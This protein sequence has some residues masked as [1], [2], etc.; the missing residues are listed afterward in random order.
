MAGLRRDGLQG[1]ASRAL[2]YVLT[3]LLAFGTT[4]A[5]LWAEG[6]ESLAA[7]ASQV[8][9]DASGAVAP[10]DAPASGDAPA[11]DA[12]PTDAAD[13]AAPDGLPQ[14]PEPAPAPVESHGDRAMATLDSEWYVV[15]QASDAD[16]DSYDRVEDAPRPGTTIFANVYDFDDWRVAADPSWSYQWMSAPTKSASASDYEPIEGQTSQ[17][18]EM[19]DDLAARLAGRYIAVRVSDGSETLWGPA[20]FGGGGLYA[21]HVLG[22]VQA[23][24]EHALSRVE[25]VRSGNRVDNDID[26]LLAPGDE[27]EARAFS[28]GGIGGGGAVVDPAEVEFAWTLLDSKDAGSGESLGS[29]ARVALRDDASMIGKYVKLEARSG[30]STV[31]CVKGP[32]AKKGALRLANISIEVP[33]GK[34]APST[35]DVLKAK[36][37][38]TAGKLPADGAVTYTWSIKRAGSPSFVELPG[39]TSKSIAVDDSWAGARL[40]VS[41]TA[42]GYN[43]VEAQT[44]VILA[45]G[46]AEA[47]VAALDADGF[48]PSPVYGGAENVAKL[49]DARLAALGHPDATVRVVSATT[50][51]G[52]ATVSASSDAANGDVAFYYEDPETTDRPAGKGE[53]RVEFAIELGG[54]VATWTRYVTI[55]WDMGRVQK[56][57]EQELATSLKASDL[58]KF[59]GGEADDAASTIAARKDLKLPRALSDW[60]TLE[61][62]SSDP[63]V[64]GLDG[65]VER[66]QDRDSAPVTLTATAAFKLADRSEPP[67]RAEKRFT[68]VAKAVVT[69]TTD[70][71]RIEAALDGFQFKAAGTS[72]PVDPASITGDVQLPTYRSLGLKGTGKVSY[73]LE[74]VEAGALELSGFRLNAKRPAPGMPDAHA[75]LVATVT[76]N[77]TTRSRRFELTVKALD[78]AEIDAEL[79]LMEKAKAGYADALLNGNASA[80]AVSS[81]LKGFQQVRLDESGELVWARDRAQVHGQ[82]I[83]PVSVDV[84]RPSEQ[85]D[86]FKSST[87]SI[88]ESETLRLMRTPEYNTRVTVTSCLSSEKYEGYYERYRDDESIDPAVLAKYK[89][90]SRQEVSATFTVIGTTGRPDPEAG[91]GV[92]VSARVVGV[93]EPAADGSVREETWIPLTEVA[94]EKGDGKTAWDVF[95]SALDD[96]GYTY[97]RKGGDP[98][99]ITAPDGRVLAMS[100]SAPWSYWSFYLNGEYAQSAPSTTVLADGDVIELRYAIAG[101]SILPENDIDIDPSA[102]RP[103]WG[104]DWPSFTEAN[105]PTTAPTPVEAVDEKWVLPLGGG[106]L[107]VVS[108]P[109]MA[110]DYIYAAAA[111]SL[112]KIDAAT[113]ADLAQGKLASKIDSTARMVYH[114]GIIVV[115]L[116]GGRLQALTADTLTTVWLTDALPDLDGAA[117]QSLG[118]LVVRDGYVFAGTTN[119]SNGGP[120]YMTCV[121]LKTGAVRWTRRADAG[122]YWAG[123]VSVGAYLVVG[124]DAGRVYSYDPATG[125]VRGTPCELGA[126]VRTTLVTDGNHVYAV[127]YDGVLHKLAV[128]G[129]GSVTEVSKISFGRTSSSSTPTIVGGKAVVCGQSPTEGSGP[130]MK[131]AAIFLIDLETMKVEREVTKTGSGEPLPTAP[132][133]ATPLVSVQPDGTYAYFTVNSLPGGVYRYKLGDDTVD[134]VY[135]PKAEHQQYCMNSVIAGADGSLYYVNSSGTL[136]AVSGAPS[137]TVSFDL[138]DGTPAGRV[139]VRRG[140][141]ASEP[142][143][144]VREG[145]AFRG[146]FI[147]AACTKAWDFSQAVPGDMTLFAKWERDGEP[148][149][150]EGGG[151]G[152]TQRPGGPSS[153]AQGAA[154]EGAS[155]PSGSVAPAKRPVSTASK[156]VASGAKGAAPAP[157]AAAPSAEGAVAGASAAEGS[158]RRPYSALA[159]AAGVLGAAGVLL[160]GFWMLVNRR[161]AAN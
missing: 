98:Y 90:L 110:G 116:S 142:A 93:S 157:E 87:P 20:L 123:S 85:W 115:P 151:N 63:G 156:A 153:Q 124:D 108:E 81:S 24:G 57:L 17:S 5:E 72:D 136:I 39:E 67:A 42:G 79:A 54:S 13:P 18:L 130:Y 34:S 100:D 1:T 74:G 129:D 47:A 36:P 48:T 38:L 135:T 137:Y 122:F 138:Q 143:A 152:S 150:P 132:A 45:A 59:E 140:L 60:A 103:D 120:G 75:A 78:T 31:S 8:V 61:W 25:M 52:G 126:R 97:S 50:G 33:G 55:R 56:R 117:I 92:T 139:F 160:A 51:K 77:E 26:A 22:P 113:G 106:N 145:Y 73:A 21:E 105:K 147:D 44:P 71:D 99:S 15:I 82:G 95:A 32:I 62:A 149:R 10:D 109:I 86:R 6:A 3:F 125:E 69:D 16:E 2:V 146:W 134:M 49:V 28:G 12:A 141:A 121:N 30:S 37:V 84:S 80:D 144:P 29:A 158:S 19:T 83:V 14:A 66:E 11:P 127:S 104:S 43:V 96:A 118:T 119:G 91:R 46:S 155:R 7:A 148:G 102:P 68:V 128:A 35:G 41:A 161:R 65:T 58:V 4:P 101:A 154:G 23:P 64:V 9:E 94:F 88:I 76:K 27:L 89:A 131:R 40:K 133:Q 114:Q 70:A 107:D 111:D 112:H 53:S 159:L